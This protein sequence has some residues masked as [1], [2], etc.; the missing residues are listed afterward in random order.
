V[1]AYF[2]GSGAPAGK[3]DTLLADLPQEIAIYSGRI[4]YLHPLKKGARFE[5]GLKSSIVK[6]DNNAVY[7]SISYGQVVRDL[8][9][10]N[11]FIYEENINAAYVNLSTPLSAKLNAQLGLRVENTIAKGRQA[12]TGQQFE[13]NYTQLFP[14]VYFQYKANEKNNF[15]LNYGRRIRRPNYQS[16]NPFIEFLDRYT[17]Q[18]GNPDL[19]P[20]FSHNIE[21]SHTFRNFLTTTLN[22]S[23][24]NDIIQQVIQQKGQEAYVRQENI[25]SARQ[26]GISV[27]SNMPITKWWTNSLY[28]NVFNNR[29]SGII[30]STSVTVEATTLALN[31]SQQF[32]L[33]KTWSAEISGFYRTSGME[34]V[35]EIG[36]MGMIA[37][38]LSKQVFQGKGS[39]R[40]NVRD[41]FLMQ[42]TK[43]STVYANVDMSFTEAR[44]SRVVNLGFTWRFS[45]GKMSNVKKRNGGSAGDEQN[46]VGVGG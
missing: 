21:A 40:L 26:I 29:F 7:D 1:N 6:T 10:S 12:T 37:V 46:R 22:Y 17:Y 39:L 18:Q 15:G 35:M 36:P 3:A 28:V 42:R 16:M 24:T 45:K 9:R 41:I 43:G 23:E 38:G 4:D 32:K 34:G 44:D 25:A 30:D 2:D 27:S 11:Y 8:N 19:K 20:Q 33:S 14:T 31:G 5:A 13:R